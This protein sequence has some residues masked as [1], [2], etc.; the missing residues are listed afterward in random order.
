MSE[1]GPTVGNR[2]IYAVAGVFL[3][4]EI[5]LHWIVWRAYS[6]RSAWWH[7]WLKT[8]L[9]RMD[10]FYLFMGISSACLFALLGYLIGQHHDDLEMNSRAARDD[11]FELS[12]RADSDGLTGLL[13]ARA[14]HERLELELEN[15]Y[16]SPL[17]CLLI[18]IDHFKKINDK[19]GHPFGDTVLKRISNILKKSLRHVDTVGRLGGEEFMVI[20]PHTNQEKAL[21][22]AERIR[23]MI[24]KDC[25]E[26][27]GKRVTV[28]V[29]IGLVNYPA[30]QLRTREDLFNAAD[31]ALYAAKH[32]GRNRVLCWNK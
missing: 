16:R 3:G 25:F 26:L 9:H 23:K 21:A 22:I 1:T 13:N 14:T 17:T 4:F 20:L 11:N 27:A 7:M 24:E 12:Q 10:S 32:A 30:D 18:D 28:T 8:E 6:A 31:E 5:P 19:Y 15:S 2:I 29:S